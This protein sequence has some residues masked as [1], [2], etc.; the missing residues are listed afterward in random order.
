[1]AG[2]EWNDSY[3]VHVDEIDRQHQNLVKIIRKLEDAIRS[4]SAQ[5]TLKEVLEDL[6]KY[7]G[8]HFASEERIF[9]LIDYPGAEN[10]RR[11][12]L[13]FVANITR[14]KREFEEG[15]AG[16]VVEVYN[17]L[18]DWARNHMRKVDKE[19]ADIIARQH[20]FR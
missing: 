20:Q 18:C 15:N 7:L 11:E 10:H 12:H 6:T 1:M 2:I 16:L 4:G 9:K 13:G 17:F 19:Y 5:A 3:S 14:C 8:E